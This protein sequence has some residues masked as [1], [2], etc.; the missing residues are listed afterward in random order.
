MDFKA[1][2]RLNSSQV[3]CGESPLKFIMNL[4][5]HVQ[6]KGNEGTSPSSGFK[7]KDLNQKVSKEAHV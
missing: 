3:V 6:V 1:N 7:E 5:V 2:S 4:G